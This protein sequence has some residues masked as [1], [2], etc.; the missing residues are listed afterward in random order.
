MTRVRL[1]D[2]FGTPLL[3][4]VTYN[5]DSAGFM[6]VEMCCKFCRVCSERLEVVEQ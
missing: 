4:R 1:N 6:N 3:L 2:G 5:M